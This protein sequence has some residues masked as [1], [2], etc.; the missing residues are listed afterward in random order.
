[1]VIAAAGEF[2]PSDRPP[3]E[4]PL[5]KLLLTTWRD[6]HRG[7]HGPARQVALRFAIL[8]ASL[9]SAARRAR[10]D[11]ARITRVLDEVAAIVAPAI[12]G[13]RH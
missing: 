1:M 5:L 13:A 10:P 4:A 12:D 2:V 3:T 8:T 6:V 11:G 9:R 7:R